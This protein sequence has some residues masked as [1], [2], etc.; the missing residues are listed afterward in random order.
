MFVS[1]TVSKIHQFIT[2]QIIYNNPVHYRSL[3]FRSSGSVKFAVSNL[4]R[5][6]G[7]LFSVKRKVNKMEEFY[8]EIHDEYNYTGNAEE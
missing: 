7:L 1:V 4:E 5:N 6:G 3:I 8:R 2:S